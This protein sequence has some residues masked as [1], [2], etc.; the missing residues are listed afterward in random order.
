MDDNYRS[1]VSVSDLSTNTLMKGW[2][3]YFVY[4]P[5][6]KGE[7]SARAFLINPAYEH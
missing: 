4:Y 5:K 3:K 6:K 1:S 2:M 7:K